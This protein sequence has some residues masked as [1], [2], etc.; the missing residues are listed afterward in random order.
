M[1]TVTREK[2]IRVLGASLDGKCHRCCIASR[3]DKARVARVGTGLSVLSSGRL[4]KSL[5]PGPRCIDDESCPDFELPAVQAIDSLDADHPLAV[6]EQSLGLDV[7][8]H[9]ATE[10]GGG[11]REGQHEAWWAMHLAIFEHRRPGESF[12]SH[13]W[14]QPQ[15]LLAAEKPCAADTPSRI[16]NLATHIGAESVVEQHAGSEQPLAALA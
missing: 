11:G 2:R 12:R 14:K 16:V 6:H 8:G 4:Q 7:V 15:S 10:L 5:G 3:H 13:I 1:S 9:R